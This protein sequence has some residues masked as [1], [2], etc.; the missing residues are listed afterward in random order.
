MLVVAWSLLCHLFCQIAY[1]LV[2][3]YLSCN[4]HYIIIAISRCLPKQ[5]FAKL[6][7]DFSF[8][9]FQSISSLSFRCDYNLT[10]TF[11]IGF[12]FMV[13]LL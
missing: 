6:C 7:C 9:N 13:G 1:I 8:V 2:K 10:V 5:H 4:Y 11:V 12:N 3:N